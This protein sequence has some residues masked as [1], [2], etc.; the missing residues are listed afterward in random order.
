MV[1]CFETF[2]LETRLICPDKLDWAGCKNCTSHIQLR[3]CT[4]WRAST[5]HA[6]FSCVWLGTIVELLQDL[7]TVEG[8]CL[9][10]CACFPSSFASRGS[11]VDGGVVCSCGAAWGWFVSGGVVGSLSFLGCMGDSEGY[12]IGL[13]TM[14]HQFQSMKLFLAFPGIWCHA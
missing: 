8:S 11:F 10:I 7:S 9:F 4:F 5:P 1:S 3:C 13:R 2:H 12:A 6:L 14:P